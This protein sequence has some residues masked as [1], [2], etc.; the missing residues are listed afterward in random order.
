M[1]ALLRCAFLL[2]LI[3]APLGAQIDPAE[4]GQLLRGPDDPPFVGT[5]LGV[6][7]PSGSLTIYAHS[8]DGHLFRLHG[9]LAA[10]HYEVV[11]DSIRFEGGL[12]ELIGPERATLG[13]RIRRDSLWIGVD[14][15]AQIRIHTPEGAADPLEGKWTYTRHG[16]V[17]VVE[18]TRDRRYI[19]WMVVGG[20]R[21]EL[22][23]DTLVLDVGG[24]SRRSIWSI[25]GD[26]LT[27]RDDSGRVARFLRVDDPAELEIPL[28][29]TDD[30]RTAN[31]DVIRA[32]AERFLADGRIATYANDNGLWG[33]YDV[34]ANGIRLW[35]E[36]MPDTNVLAHT[37]AHLAAHALGYGAT[38]DKEWVAEEVA[39]RCTG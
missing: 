33:F 26:L 37:T 14:D 39:R 31:C 20:P 27:I 21:Y 28:G 25:N 4:L 19:R 18:F 30:P 10:S 9:S 34:Q 8:P 2:A 11:D 7:D 24:V 13:F 17:F 5:W 3:P 38:P 15:L 36:T 16:R 29:A 23:A 35:K 6:D 32:T 12:G 22:L 1:R